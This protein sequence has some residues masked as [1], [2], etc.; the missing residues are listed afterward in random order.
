M[1]MPQRQPCHTG[2]PCH[3]PHHCQTQEPLPTI[4]RAALQ[5]SMCSTPACKTAKAA[6]DLQSLSA[7]GCPRAPIL[8]AH[9]KALVMH[10][11]VP[12][13]M[14]RIL[15]IQLAPWH[16]PC[17]P[18]RASLVQHLLHC[19]RGCPGISMATAAQRVRS[20]IAS[21]QTRARLRRRANFAGAH[22]SVGR[23]SWSCTE[24][25]AQY[26]GCML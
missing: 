1:C 22:I 7:N 14:D 21:R 2:R 25:R 24:P 8:G 17:R 19:Q 11:T 23:V 18:L 16:G 12:Q 20:R 26:L 3:Q 13:H 4:P 15:S 10:S 9:Q 6:G 5:A